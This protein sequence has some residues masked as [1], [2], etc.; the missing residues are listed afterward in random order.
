MDD[1]RI[2]DR[3]VRQAEADGAHAG[4]AHAGAAHALRDGVVIPRDADI[5]GDGK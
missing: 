1:E 4:A 2:L 5:T 3:A